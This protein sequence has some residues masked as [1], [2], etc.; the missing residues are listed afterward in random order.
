MLLGL[1]TPDRGD[2]DHLRP[3]VPGT[4]EPAARGRRGSR[5][6]RR[7]PGPYRRNHLRIHALAGQVPASRVEEVHELVD[8]TPAAGRRIGRRPGGLT[9]KGQQSCQR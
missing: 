2:R 6:R 7:P 3:P 5:L 1:V 4:G 9:Q 8:L